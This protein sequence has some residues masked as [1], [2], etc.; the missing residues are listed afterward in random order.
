MA[1]VLI[2]E[3]DKN[4]RTL[5][6]GILVDFGHDVRQCSDARD[7]RECL[8]TAR[9]DALVTDLPCDGPEGVVMLTLDGGSHVAPPYPGGARDTGAPTR[10]RDKPFRISVLQNLVTAVAAL[11]AGRRLAA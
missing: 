10:L 9:F 2:I 4:T 8:R 11:R 6:A 3:P 7:A 5:I 1:R